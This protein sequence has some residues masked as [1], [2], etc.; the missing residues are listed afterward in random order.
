MRRSPALGPWRTFLSVSPMSDFVVQADDHRK[1]GGLNRLIS[2]G[3][4]WSQFVTDQKNAQSLSVV[5][6]AL[7]P[8]GHHY[9]SIKSNAS[10]QRTTRAVDGEGKCAVHIS[11]DV[12]QKRPNNSRLETPAC[13]ES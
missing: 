12:S 2:F 6:A 5:R 8:R 13:A 11:V 7:A 4:K 3:R 1:S 10:F 9:A